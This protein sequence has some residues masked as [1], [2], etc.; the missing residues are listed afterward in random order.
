MQKFEQHSNVDLRWII[1]VVKYFHIKFLDETS[2]MMMQ[3]IER[4][5]NGKI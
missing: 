2:R 5:T 4:E 3:A 1:I